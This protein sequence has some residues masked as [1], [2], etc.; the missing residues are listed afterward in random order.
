MVYLTGQNQLAAQDSFFTDFITSPGQSTLYAVIF[1]LLTAWIVFNGVEKGIEQC[2]KILMPVMLVM[3]V[4]IAIF[5][6]TLTHT[7]EAGVTRTA[8]RHEPDFLL[9]ERFHGHY[10]HL[11][12]LHQEGCGCEHVYPPD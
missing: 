4:A 11:W 12:I 3:I 9:P 1:M 5:A 6:L 7:D 8:G 2:S 10:D